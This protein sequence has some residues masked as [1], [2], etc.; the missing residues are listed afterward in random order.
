MYYGSS[1]TDAPVSI[2]VE[3]RIPWTAGTSYIVK[4]S[5]ILLPNN[6]PT[7]DII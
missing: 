7:N 5:K 1:S 6:N 4:I 3:S 2:V